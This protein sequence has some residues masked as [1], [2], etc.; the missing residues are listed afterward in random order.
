MHPTRCGEFEAHPEGP[1][2]YLQA[3]ADVIADGRRDGKVVAI[4][5][6]G[7]D[8]DRLHFCGGGM[9]RR[10]FEAQFALAAAHR[11]PMFLHL[12]AAAADFLDIIN[13]HTDD[14]AAGG[15]V[16]SFDGTEAE[17]ARLLQ[18]PA[19][20]VGVNGCSLKIGGS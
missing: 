4:G 19:L 13:R 15:V 16:H 2:A 5:E 11:L 10:W 18:L 9:Q 3:L 14:M 12:R 1:D 8:Y 7:L 17:L 20:R 6:A